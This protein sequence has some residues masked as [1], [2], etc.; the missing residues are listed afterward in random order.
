MKNR[1][2]WLNLSIFVSTN[3]I[4]MTKIRL[5]YRIVI[6]SSSTFIWDKYVFEDTYKEYLMQQQLFNTKANPK[7]TFRELISEN[8]K[9]NQLHYLVGM[10]ANAYV[11]QLK[12]NFHRVTDVLGKHF[13]P[14]L[15]FQL[16][17]I[18]SD[19]TD[20]SKHRIGITFYSPLLVL[21]DTTNQQYLLS[22]EVEKE[23]EFQTL[24]FQM[25]PNLAICYYEK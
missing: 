3:F 9:A 17:I 21:I 16:D 12:G 19:I 5:A 18:N 13:F 25:Q 7:A 22:T 1:E 15:N 6:D 2:I 14:F 8:E 11:G 23:N 4:F 10:A 24:V 20:I